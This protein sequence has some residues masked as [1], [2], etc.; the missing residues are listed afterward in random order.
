M[1]FVRWEA[2]NRPV[3]DGLRLRKLDGSMQGMVLLTESLAVW[4]AP[5]PAEIA[6]LVGLG[7]DGASCHGQTH[8]SCPRVATRLIEPERRGCTVDTRLSLTSVLLALRG[9][10]TR[11]M[12]RWRP[13]H[14]HGLL[15]I[16]PNSIL[17]LVL[18]I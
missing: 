8:S 2:E 3:K 16:C 15:L 5:R 1:T 13:R 9:G 17:M 6:V 18:R 7:F 14:I 12:M 11:S 10:G 4:R